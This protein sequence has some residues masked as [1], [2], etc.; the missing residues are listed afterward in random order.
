[1]P[2]R[3]VSSGAHRDATFPELGQQG[4]QG[5]VRL[6]RNPL[7]QPF[8]LFGQCKLPLAADWQSGGLPVSRPR[9]T[10]RIAEDRL[11]S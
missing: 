6:R 7:L 1:M 9:L 3:V 5:D 11:T 2:H 4:T 8:P 10:Q